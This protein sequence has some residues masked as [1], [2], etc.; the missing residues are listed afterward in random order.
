MSRSN[1]VLRLFIAA[2]GL[3]FVA[4]V[5]DDT[6][7]QMMAG[8]TVLSNSAVPEFDIMTTM[9]DDEGF[10]AATNGLHYLVGYSTGNLGPGNAF[11]IVKAQTI[12]STGTLLNLVS[13]GRIGVSPKVAFDGT[14]YL[15]A[16]VDHN[17]GLLGPVNVFG[18]RIDAN[19][20][21]VGSA[22]RISTE[23]NVVFLSGLA[24]GGGKYLVTY[25]YFDINSV[26]VKLYGR[27]V[28]TTGV[29]GARFIITSPQTTGALNNL[30]T[31]GTNFLATWVTGT[32]METVKARIVQGSGA[33][34]SVITLN[35]S[36]EPSSQSL[37][38]AY[39]GGKYLVTWSDS[40]GL[41][42]S[43]VYGRM[44]T[45]AG[46]AT[47]GRITISGAAGQQIGG[48]AT[49]IGQNFFV[50]WIDFQPDPA[51]TTVKGRFFSTAGTALGTV[52]TLY[53][54]DQVTGKMPLTPGPI[55]R[56]SDAFF[57]IGRA[58]PGPDPQS[59]ENLNGWDL[60]GGVKNLVP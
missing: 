33:L 36:P 47:G 13:T 52:K 56:G 43:N 42:E 9:D 38:V 34:G 54:T 30:A 10:S 50:T 24:F 32:D 20:N 48:L 44:V 29:V 53:T 49:A 7:P 55:A 31:D 39:L 4:C 41:H 27:F 22:F 11:G 23:S 58:L 6:A 2:A 26:T 21:K 5:E 37:G 40:M 12:S 60:H 16:W 51:N 25:L 14:N 28:S 19:G 57:V 1:R 17:G 46:A 18:Q 3:A 35:S 59:F 15:L 45:Q 8:P